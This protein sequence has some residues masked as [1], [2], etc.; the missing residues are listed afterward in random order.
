ML[1]LALVHQLGPLGDRD[2]LLGHEERDGEL[3]ADGVARALVVGM[4]MRQRVRRD[5][6]G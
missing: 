5:L 4:R 3:G 6:V 1:G 2:V